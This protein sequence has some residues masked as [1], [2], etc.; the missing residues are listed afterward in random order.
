MNKRILVLGKASQLG[1]S[2]E[3]LLK[4]IPNFFDIENFNSKIEDKYNIYNWEFNF[5]SREDL[6]LSNIKSINNFF[7]IHKFSGIVNFA[8]YTSVNMAENK[9]DLAKQINHIAVQKLAEISAKQNIPLIHI[10]TDYVFNGKTTKPFAESDKPDPINV[11]GLTKFNGEEAIIDSGCNGAI[12]RTSWLYSEYGKNFL[13][14]I[15]TLAKTKKSIDVV[16]DQI[17]SPTYAK[18]LA[19]AILEMFS[20]K[21]T[22]E[23]LN[24]Q[25]NIYH[26]SDNGCC[27]WYEF[28]K[29]IIQLSNLSC[30]VKS[31]ETIEHPSIAKRPHYSVLD[32]KKINNYIS[33]IERLHWRDSLNNCIQELKKNNFY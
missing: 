10:S 18:N 24:T 21:E 4:D 20:Y 27:S 6:D 15:L 12:I 23:I 1:K 31:I 3:K 14:T 2:L 16:R 28:A 7:N 17:G 11:Y 19:K 29:E 5:I 9:V 22:F 26:F 32:N 30:K 25:L 13:K 33:S 8:A